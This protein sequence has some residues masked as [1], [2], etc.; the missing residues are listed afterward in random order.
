MDI[1][2]VHKC[3]IDKMSNGKTE[4]TKFEDM[5]PFLSREEIQSNILK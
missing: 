5:Y 3:F 1:K 2:K 4:P